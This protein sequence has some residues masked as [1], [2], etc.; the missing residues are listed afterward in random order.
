MKLTTEPLNL[1]LL[2]DLSISY[3]S[4]N[5]LNNVLI[6]LEAGGR[7]GYGEAAPHVKYGETQ[8]TVLALLDYLAKELERWDD[9]LQFTEICDRID[10]LITGNEATKAAIDMALYDL[11]GKL[12]GVPVYQLL[13]LNP[14]KTT[15]LTYTIGLDSVDGM[16]KKALAN[17]QYPYLKVKLGT[18]YDKEIIQAITEVTTATLRVDVNGGWEARH[19]LRFINDVLV[20]YPVEFVEQPLAVG[21]YAGM[22]LLHQSSVLPIILDESIAGMESI[23]THA[24]FVDGVNIKLMKCGGIHTALRMIHTARALGLKVMLGCRVETSL[25]ITAAVHLSPLVDF[26]DLDLHL[27]LA[28]DPFLGAT[29]DAK[30]KFVLPDAPGLGVVLKSIES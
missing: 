3:E 9:P 16:V 15:D 29:L 17:A 10:H 20:H 1:P 5:T 12:L 19:A 14:Q 28:D 22:K 13:G 11:A 21:D 23:L 30:G 18:S 26:A 2:E 24:E 4:V 6:R 27:L 8:A 7:T 25:A